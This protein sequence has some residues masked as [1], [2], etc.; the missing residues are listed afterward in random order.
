MNS[1]ETHL[2]VA[3][4]DLIITEGLSLNISQKPRFK[5]VINLAKTVS[6]C[7]QPHN[8]KLIS[9]DLLGV[10]HNQNTESKMSLI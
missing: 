5:K 1:N 2:T 4:S 3:I 9:K 10:I 8:R 6:K 7:Y